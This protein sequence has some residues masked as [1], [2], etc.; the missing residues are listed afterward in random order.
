MKRLL[1]SL[2]FVALVTFG[3]VGLSQAGVAPVLT[4]DLP[5]AFTVGD[6]VFPA[7]HYIV[8]MN[9][10]NSSA[11]I[12]S[13]LTLR[14]EDGQLIKTVT[15]LPNG[16]GELKTGSWLTFRKYNN[17]YFL[18]KVESFGIGCELTRTP[19]EKEMASGRSNGG[20]AV[21]VAAE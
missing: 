14:K 10:V 18:A 7:G 11:A 6:S 4:V 21:T 8:Q 17:T 9:R 12:G 3:T 5:F 15:A 13:L 16:R 19:A 1:L 20:T 2:V